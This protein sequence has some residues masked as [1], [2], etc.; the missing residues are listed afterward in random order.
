[1][2]E[3]CNKLKRGNIMKKKIALFL[4]GALALSSLVACSDTSADGLIETYAAVSGTMADYANL[5]VTEV[6]LIEVTDDDIATGLETLCNANIQSTEITDRAVESGDTVDI[7]YIGYLDGVAFDGGTA[8]GASLEIG[9]GSYIDGFEDGLIGA[10]IGD[11]VSLELTFAEDYGSD[12]LNGQDVIFEVII[13]AITVEIVPELTDELIQEVSDTCTTIE[14]YEAELRETYEAENLALQE[15]SKQEAVWTALVDGTVLD[16]YDDDAVQVTVDYL[17]EVYEYQAYY[18]YGW[19][20]AD[21]IS[22]MEMTEDEFNAYLLTMAQQ[23]YVSDVIISYVGVQEDLVPSDEEFQTYIDD[24]M[25]LYGYDD[26]E[27]FLTD[28]GMTRDEV[29]L[30]YLSEIVLDY[31]VGIATFVEAEDTTETTEDTAEATEE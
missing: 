24:I 30:E 1:M 16:E 29:D 2:V 25:T 6:D 8:E 28:M 22:A 21:F 12:E 13:N 18:Y 26:E 23:A 31:V 15:S 20:M 11:T 27:T 7:D 17:Y 9:S 3:D 5:E 14:E 4:V 19:E 10:N